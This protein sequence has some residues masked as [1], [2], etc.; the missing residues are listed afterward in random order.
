MSRYLP[1]V[2]RI[3][4]KTKITMRVTTLMILEA[5]GHLRKDG[6]CFIAYCDTSSL[7]WK[8]RQSM[9]KHFENEDV[10]IKS[11]PGEQEDLETG[12]KHPGYYFKLIRTSKD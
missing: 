2:F 10:T 7:A 3:T 5:V 11:T 6:E 1:E 12:K 9:M 8:Y 4:D